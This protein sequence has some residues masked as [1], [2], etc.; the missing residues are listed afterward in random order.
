MPVGK[1][2]V[3]LANSRK[4]GGR[5]IAGKEWHDNRPGGWIRPVSDRSSKELSTHE[6]RY[7]DRREPR[8]LDIIDISLLSQAVEG[9]QSENWL[10]DRS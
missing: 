9:H 2:I 10:I 5:C 1:R 6:C 8:L 3:C 7:E 4:L